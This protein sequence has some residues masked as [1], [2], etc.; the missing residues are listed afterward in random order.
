MGL[1]LP[2]Q[3]ALS[4]SAIILA[5]SSSFLVLSFTWLFATFC[6][7]FSLLSF[8]QC[9]YSSERVRDQPSEV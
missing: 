8:R 4:V 9:A 1:T 5:I 3:D 2:P 6:S 7:W